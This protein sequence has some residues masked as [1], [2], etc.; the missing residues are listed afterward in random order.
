M[1]NEEYLAFVRTNWKGPSTDTE[2]GH[3]KN[4]FLM[5]SGLTGEAGEVVDA[6]KKEVRDNVFK[7]NEIKLELGDL[8]HYLVKVADHYNLTI[9]DLQ[10]SNVEKLT[11]REAARCRT[12]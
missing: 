7:T 2:A 5:T 4:L 8:L 6:M 11:A 10:Q 12:V 9:E 3:Y 1:T